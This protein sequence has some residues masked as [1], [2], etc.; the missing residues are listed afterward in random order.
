MNEI[1]KIE[2]VVGKL[3]DNCADLHALKAALLE[4]FD[5]ERQELVAFALWWFGMSIKGVEMWV[6]EWKLMTATGAGSL[7]EE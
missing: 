1:D 3:Q 4:P 6:E 2:A 7:D 5:D